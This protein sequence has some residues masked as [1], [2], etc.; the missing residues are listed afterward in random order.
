MIVGII[1][2]KESSDE[3]CL[4]EGRLLRLPMDE[5]DGP[6]LTSLLSSSELLVLVLVMR[7]PPRSR[8]TAVLACSFSL[9]KSIPPGSRSNPG[10]TLPDR[11]HCVHEGLSSSHLMRL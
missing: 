10:H 6:L 4:E 2:G 9:T 11:V 7:A 5:A 1:S 8:G 3:D